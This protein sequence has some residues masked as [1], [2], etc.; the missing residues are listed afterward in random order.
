MLAKIAAMVDGFD[1]TDTARTTTR[2]L[3]RRG[4]VRAAAL[5]LGA[6]ALT[7]AAP[8]GQALAS[9]DEQRPGGQGQA[10]YQGLAALR[11]LALRQPGDPLPMTLPGQDWPIYVNPSGAHTFNHP[12]TWGIQEIAWNDGLGGQSHVGAW[13]VAPDGAAAVRSSTL[14]VYQ[15]VLACDAA[16][17]T[18]QELA[19]GAEISLIYD[20]HLETGNASGAFAAAEFGGMLAAVFVTAELNP[21]REGAAV[22]FKVAVGPAAA[23]DALTEQVFL[24]FFVQ[25]LAGGNPDVVFIDDNGDPDENEDEN[26][27]EEE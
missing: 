17:Q 10:G 16:I 4:F 21:P 8:R 2:R 19:G 7:A 5:G 23:F 18:L 27:D 22:E 15:S 1:G 24:P 11:E 26:D 20:D 9:H 13:A 12:P 14:L 25:F 6:T 3:S